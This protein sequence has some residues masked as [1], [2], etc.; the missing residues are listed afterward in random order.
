MDVEVVVGEGIYDPEAYHPNDNFREITYEELIN[1]CG[2][3][4]EH[5]IG[6]QVTVFMYPGNG[7]CT[8]CDNKEELSL[9]YLYFRYCPKIKYNI[10]RPAHPIYGIV[11]CPTCDAKSLDSVD[12]RDWYDGWDNW[13]VST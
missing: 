11:L 8:L 1:V 9:R 5:P 10:T 2:C 4:N 3:G 13:D 6:C 7:K 12:G